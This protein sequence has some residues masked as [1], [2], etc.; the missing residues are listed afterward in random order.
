MVH[1]ERLH[2]LRGF[3]PNA[4]K[5]L[6]RQLVQ[7]GVGLLGWDQAQT[8]GFVETRRDLR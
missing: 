4:L 3:A 7:E 1:T 5:A 2:L 8:I 6:D